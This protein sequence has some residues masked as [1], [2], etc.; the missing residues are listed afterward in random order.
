MF[1]LLVRLMARVMRTEDEDGSMFRSQKSPGQPPQPAIRLTAHPPERHRRTDPTILPCACC[2]CCCCCLHS[3]GSLIGGIIGSVKS[4][5]LPPR[6]IDDPNFPFPFRRDELDEEGPVF[7]AALLYW[8]LV[9]LQ[10]MGGAI[11]YYLSQGRRDP[12]DLL[13]GGV[14][15]LALLPVPQ[16]GASILSMIAVFLFYEDRRTALARIGKITLYSFMGTMIGLVMLGL[17]CGM[18]SLPG[19]F[20]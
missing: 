9:S 8:V 20:R 4:L 5:D 19:L 12:N 16:L 1:G 6:E 14:M 15:G 3:I 18:L 13:L 10:L 11:W 17:C 7:P 2:S